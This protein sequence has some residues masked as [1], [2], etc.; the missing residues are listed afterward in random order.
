MKVVIRREMVS[1][2]G[3]HDRVLGHGEEGVDSGL[4]V[5][6]VAVEQVHCSGDAEV[7]GKLNIFEN[8]IFIFQNSKLVHLV[9]YLH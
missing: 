8:A 3:H 5:R 1:D 4:A 7:V 6:V 9:T 2:V